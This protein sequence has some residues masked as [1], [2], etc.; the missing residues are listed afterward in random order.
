MISY[1]IIT[2]ASEESY[3]NPFPKEKMNEKNLKIEI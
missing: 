3:I 2:S 1:H